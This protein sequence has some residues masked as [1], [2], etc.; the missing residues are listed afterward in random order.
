MAQ[1]EIVAGRP[2]RDLLYAVHS[3]DIPFSYFEEASDGARSHSW[4]RDLVRGDRWAVRPPT[5]EA[6]PGLQKLFKVD[7]EGL[8]LL[9]AEEWYGVTT[10]VEP[11]TLALAQRIEQLEGEDYDAVVTFLDKVEK[12]RPTDL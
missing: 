11:E 4:F 3:Q 5:P 12:R 8:M 10:E 7:E 2:I 6:F 1:S 9:I